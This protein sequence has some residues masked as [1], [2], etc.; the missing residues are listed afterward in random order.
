MT[1]DHPPMDPA[2]RRY[3]KL[4]DDSDV[5]CFIV[6]SGTTSLQLRRRLSPLNGRR[7]GDMRLH[8]PSYDNCLFDDRHSL[9]D[10]RVSEGDSITILY[11]LPSGEFPDAPGADSSD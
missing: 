4:K 9:E 1:A 11:R 5:Y 10:A 3:V 8:L 2:S 7:V 6:D